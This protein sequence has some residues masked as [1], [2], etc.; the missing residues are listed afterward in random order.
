MW[1]AERKTKLIL[2]EF[3]EHRPICDICREAGISPVRY[4]QWREQFIDAGQA[5]FALR[6]NENHSLEEQVRQLK[7]ENASLQRQ[8]R[9]LQELCLA[10]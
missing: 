7:T 2:E 5:S 1:P 9:I 10:E 6:E 8:L 3:D 4:R